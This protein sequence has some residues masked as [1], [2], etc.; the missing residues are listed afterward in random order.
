MLA[1]I[2]LSRC[3]KIDAAVLMFTFCTQHTWQIDIHRSW[4]NCNGFWDS[5]AFFTLL[6]CSAGRCVPKNITLIFLQTLESSACCN[7]LDMLLAVNFKVLPFEHFHVW[8]ISC[9]SQHLIDSGL[10]KLSPPS[11][12]TGPSMWFLVL[13]T[14]SMSYSSPLEHINVHR[15]PSTILFHVLS[16]PRPCQFQCRC[17]DNFSILTFTVLSSEN[18]VLLP[19]IPF[20]NDHNNYRDIVDVWA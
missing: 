19:R 1:P 12:P 5:S 6:S 20:Q 17:R 4:L 15:W 14:W 13:F 3:I 18:I 10:K 7:S 11:V 2:F 16:W 8:Y 9:F